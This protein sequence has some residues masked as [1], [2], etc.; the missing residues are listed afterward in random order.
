MIANDQEE[1]LLSGIVVHWHNE[2]Q[3]AELTTAWPRDPRFEL[4]VVDNG[5]SAPL[6]LGP[7]RLLRPE[8]NLGFAGGANAGIAAARAPIVLLL[9]PDAVPEDGAL[10]RLFEGF[11]AWPDAAGLAPR[12]TGMDGESQAAWQLRPLPSAWSC[13]LHALPFGGTPRPIPE[14]PA[15][16]V[17][18]QP[19]AAALA[20]RREA[21]ARI[22]GLDAGFY[23][24]WFEDVDLARRLRSDGAVL[25]YWPAARFRHHLGST[26]ARL[27][28]GPFLW[29]YYRNL[30]RYL[31]KHHGRAWALAA[32]VALVLGVMVRL[33]LLPLHRPRR[34]VSR[35]E[36]ARGLMAVLGGAVSG[37]RRPPTSSR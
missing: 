22:G 26:V 10:D 30:T 16:T 2:E 25:R 7:A 20:L 24:A 31:E 35:G 1:P 11:A 37:W 14:P 33:I 29:I 34:A 6:R 19:A 8:R 15:G 27:G 28:Y 21:L 17:V 5:S 18:E 4:L 13:L 32:R 23:P 12:L 9:N 36:A 3:L